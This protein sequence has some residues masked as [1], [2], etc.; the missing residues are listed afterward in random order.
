MEYYSKSAMYQ[1]INE[2]NFVR[3]IYEKNNLAYHN[4]THILDCLNEFNNHIHINLADKSRTY[5]FI[6]A[7]LYHDIVYVPGAEDN[8]EQSFNLFKEYNQHINEGDRF[9]FPW[10]WV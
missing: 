1:F 4:F 7:I 5:D 3:K 8:E 10:V 6:L 9:N 2:L